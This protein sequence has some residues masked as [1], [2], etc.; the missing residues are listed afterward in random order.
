MLG[1]GGTLKRNFVFET[2]K[3]S[4]VPYILSVLLIPTLFHGIYFYVMLVLVFVCCDSNILL[5][6]QKIS[7]PVSSSAEIRMCIGL[8]EYYVP[9]MVSGPWALMIRTW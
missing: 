1:L 8:H 5:F 6:K 4:R 9:G 2:K 3:E 7:V